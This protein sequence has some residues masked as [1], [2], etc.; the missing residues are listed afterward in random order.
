MFMFL[1]KIYTFLLVPEQYTLRRSEIHFRWRIQLAVNENAY[2]YYLVRPVD[3]WRYVF[4]ILTTGFYVVVG[5]F[6]S[7]KVVLCC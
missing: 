7:L 3:T 6:M 4:A 1:Q 2:S 5:G